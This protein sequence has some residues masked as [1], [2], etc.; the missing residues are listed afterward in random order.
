[1][2]CRRQ[3]T[4][5]LVALALV[6]LLQ[7]VV[8][9]YQ[10][11]VPMLVEGIVYI[12]DDRA[13]DGTRIEAQIDGEA[14]A[15]AQTKTSE[16][17]RGQ[18]L[19]TISEIETEEAQIVFYVDGQQAQVWVDGAPQSSLA[20]A[21]GTQTHDLV[22][23]EVEQTFT[24][25]VAVAG[26]G[27]TEPGVGQHIYVEGRRVRIRAGAASGWRFDGWVG[28]VADPGATSTTVLMDGDKSI[29]AMFSEASDET[30]SV[31]PTTSPTGETVSPTPTPSATV[32]RTG[33]PTPSGTATDEPSPTST[34]TMDGT[35][36]GEGTPG[37]TTTTGE[38]SQ[39]TPTGGVGTTSVVLSATPTGSATAEAMHELD[40][41]PMA[42]GT[43]PTRASTGEEDDEATTQTDVTAPAT[44]RTDG[45]GQGSHEGR[46]RN[47]ML[48]LAAAAL[49]VVGL[50]AL[51]FGLLGLSRGGDATPDT[52]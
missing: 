52:S 8:W 34:S 42:E 5:C 11:T 21:P 7:G 51:G 20:Y 26:N 9:A 10:P 19:L 38:T 30:P 40:G 22:I 24:L 31:S 14:V 35:E 23:G 33:S 6:A 44:G 3:V 29:T 18:Y 45:N 12:N 15:S 32:D 46:D 43:E 17:I 48:V 41:S 2:S 39:L 50:V 1:M 13:P 47:L 25:E 37:G 27:A 4:G 36:E 49:G 28:D 16:G